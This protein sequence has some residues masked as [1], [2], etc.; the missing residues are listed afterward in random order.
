MRASWFKR[1]GYKVVDKDGMM[2]LLWKPFNEQAKPP[3]FMKQKKN[4]EPGSGKVNVTIF[5]NGW[6]PAHN[7]TNERARR[8]S[9][10]FAGNIDIQ[11]YETFD[12]DIV[13]EWG[14]FDSLFIEGKEVRTG[15]PPS[16]KKIRKKIEKRVRQ[17]Q[18]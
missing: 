9:A 7:I 16:F 8:A 15:P 3:L 17:K 2:R 11:E 4:P 10:E 6:C 5:R 13:K 1:H 18:A 12:R 14:I